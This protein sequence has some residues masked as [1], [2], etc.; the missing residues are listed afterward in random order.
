MVIPDLCWAFWIN[1]WATFVSY[2]SAK[3]GERGWLLPDPNSILSV[4]QIPFVLDHKGENVMHSLEKP[5]SASL[6]P[7]FVCRTGCWESLMFVLLHLPRVWI[8]HEGR[9]PFPKSLKHLGTISIL[10]LPRFSSCLGKQ[11]EHS[12]N[13]RDGNAAVWKQQH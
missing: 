11:Q 10:W 8:W 13:D 6:T 1:S 2:S 12:R 7:L 9:E 3:P 4:P 5:C